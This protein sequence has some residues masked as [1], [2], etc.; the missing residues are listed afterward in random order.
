MTRDITTAPALVTKTQQDLFLQS[1]RT[2]G[3]FTK[4]S[5]VAGITKSQIE[6]Y[7]QA[8]TADAE[9]FQLNVQEAAAQWADTIE[10]E[11]TRRAID[12]VQKGIYYKGQW[13]AD[14]TVYS[15]SLL[16]KL[17][18]V[19]NPDF[20]KAK[21]VAPPNIVISINTFQ[22]DAQPPMPTAMVVDTTATF[23]SDLE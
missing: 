21:D 15:D 12:G 18:E 3:L 6:K 22:P 10:A 4:A 2:H 16:L 8:Q 23:I 14:E 11:V 5:Q 17:I 9:Q 19:R 7:C 20:A 13:V 1:Y